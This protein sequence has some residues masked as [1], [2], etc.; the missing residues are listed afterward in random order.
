[1]LTVT[2]AYLRIDSSFICLLSLYFISSKSKAQLISGET[3]WYELGSSQL[4]KKSLVREDN[5]VY[6]SQLHLTFDVFSY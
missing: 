5:A 1:M 6:F 3:A 2:H 4:K